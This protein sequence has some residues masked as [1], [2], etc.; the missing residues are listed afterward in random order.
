MFYK[1]L[2]A[3]TMSLSLLTGAAFS[4]AVQADGDTPAVSGETQGEM[5]FTSDAER[6]MF[7][8]RMEI[9]GGFF[10]DE[11]MTTLR[12]EE[13]MGTAFSSLSLEEQQAFRDDCTNV[14]GDTSNAYGMSVV[15]L[16]TTVGGM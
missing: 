4:Q 3:A 13:E 9:M 6:A 5:T 2:A 16:C 7:E 8:S 12:T 14:T 10:T 1:T 15:E 11:T